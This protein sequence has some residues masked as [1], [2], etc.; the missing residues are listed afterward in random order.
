MTRKPKPQILFILE[1]SAKVFRRL[2]ML[3]H[4]I[5]TQRAIRQRRKR[6]I[7]GY[8]TKGLMDQATLLKSN[9]PS[10]P[11]TFHFPLHYLSSRTDPRAS[12]TDPLSPAPS[13]LLQKSPP[14]SPSHP[15][16][17]PRRPPNTS[18]AS[19]HNTSAPSPAALSA[20]PPTYHSSPP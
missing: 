20:S 14:L 11:R 17:S 18:L 6:F 8:N 10:S 3:V 7:P 13:L 16:P 2:I 4:L 1:T 9:I 19:A 15:S 5:L 12:L